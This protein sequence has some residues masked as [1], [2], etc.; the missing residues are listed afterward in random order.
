MTIEIPPL[1]ERVEDIEELTAKLMEKLSNQLGIYVPKI[2]KKA[3]E[4]LKT[5]SWPGNVRE[6]ENVLERAINLTETDTILPIHLP[7]YITQN[8]RKINPNAIDSLQNLVEQTEREAIQSCLD[9]TNGNKLK[10]AKILN[11]SRTS[12]YQKIEKYGLS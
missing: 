7:L 12:L 1:R 4:L 2:S 5:Y 3:L 6:L 11:I 10:T 8:K 9:Y